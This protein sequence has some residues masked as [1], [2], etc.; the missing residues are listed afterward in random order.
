[1]AHM[2]AVS[3]EFILD[4][5]GGTQ[6]DWLKYELLPRSLPIATNVIIPYSVRDCG[7]ISPEPI[8]CLADGST[9]NLNSCS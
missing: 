1:M 7:N 8:L 5:K 4:L 9:I 6:T 3:L 2:G